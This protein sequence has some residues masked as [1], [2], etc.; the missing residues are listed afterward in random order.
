MVLNLRMSPVLGTAPDEIWTRLRLAQCE[1]GRIYSSQLER[2]LE[3]LRGTGFQTQGPFDTTE[4]MSLICFA[5]VWGVFA[6]FQR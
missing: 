4:H 6:I 1:D 2:W 3:L 5:D